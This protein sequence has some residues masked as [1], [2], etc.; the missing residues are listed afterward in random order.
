MSADTSPQSPAFQQLTADN[1]GPVVVVTSYIFLVVSIIV[2]FTRLITR[3]QISRRFAPDDYCILVSII[4]LIGQ[5][6]AVTLAV[7]AGLGRHRSTLSDDAFDKYA[8]VC[9][10][11]DPRRPFPDV[12][13]RLFTLLECSPS[14]LYAR[15]KRQQTTLSWASNHPGH[16]CVLVKPVLP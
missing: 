13:Q 15:Q 6:V 2:V 3:F 11:I 14:R 12:L 1:R 4:F 7:N 8:K 9:F 16:S 10:P 5:T